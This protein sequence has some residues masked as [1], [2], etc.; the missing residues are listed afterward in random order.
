MDN[1]KAV[2]RAM[3]EMLST[4]DV[5]DVES[6]VGADYVDHQD[7]LRGPESF[8]ALVKRVH[9]SGES[10]AIRVE[11]LIGDGDRA[12]ARLRWTHANHDG[13]I[14][15]RETIDMIRCENGQAVEHWGAE[16]WRRKEAW[17]G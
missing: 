17:D 14:V 11:D 13:S 4:G 16:I 10:V 3:V 5:S 7:D 9:E 15:E 12:A 1:A 6:V 2:L 8:R